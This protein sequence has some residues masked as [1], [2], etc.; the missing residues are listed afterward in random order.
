[1]PFRHVAFFIK[2]RARGCGICSWAAGGR[3]WVSSLHN[4]RVLLSASP[5]VEQKSKN[6]EKCSTAALKICARVSGSR[7]KKQKLGKMF[8]RAT[9]SAVILGSAAKISLHAAR[10]HSALSKCSSASPLHPKALDFTKKEPPKI[11]RFLRCAA[12]IFFSVIRS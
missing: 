10:L 12:F 4:N 1:M 5:K 6:W 11:G 7:T 8:Y 9:S 3:V 2:C